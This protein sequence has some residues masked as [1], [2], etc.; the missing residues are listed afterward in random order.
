[1][2]QVDGLFR[3]TN[4]FCKPATFSQ[5]V[6]GE[7]RVK[8]SPRANG[9]PVYLI[10]LRRFGSRATLAARDAPAPGATSLCRWELPGYPPPRGSSVL[11]HRPTTKF[12]GARSKA[13]PSHASDPAPR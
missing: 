1:M 10:L 13:S 3:G 12:A 7:Y 2:L 8:P 11:P 9:G 4:D 6:T 5:R